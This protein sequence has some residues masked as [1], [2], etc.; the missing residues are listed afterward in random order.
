MMMQLRAKLPY[1][2]TLSLQLVKL[3]YIGDELEMV[4]ILP[5]MRFDLMNIREKMKGEDLF[6]YIRK[7]YPTEVEVNDEISFL[8]KL[9]ENHI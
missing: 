4:I 9:N 1:Y 3:P 5:K 6:N 7:A 8:S 2:E